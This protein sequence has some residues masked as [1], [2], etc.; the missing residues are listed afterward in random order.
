MCTRGMRIDRSGTRTRTRV[1]LKIKGLSRSSVYI[2]FIYKKRHLVLSRWTFPR[3]PFFFSFCFSFQDF[4]RKFIFFQDFFAF[5]LVT[6]RVIVSLCRHFLLKVSMAHT[7][8]KSLELKREPRRL[9]P[10]FSVSVKVKSKT[11]KGKEENEFRIKLRHSLSGHSDNKKFHWILMELKT[12][13]N[14]P[15]QLIR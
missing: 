7:K 2:G 6:S 8:S 9:P 4:Q 10:S 11:R 1:G 13:V 15:F 14:S 5:L 12:Q 3:I